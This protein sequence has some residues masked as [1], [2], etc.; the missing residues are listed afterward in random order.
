MSSA[1]SLNS[2]SFQSLRQRE[3]IKIYSKCKRNYSLFQKESFCFRPVN[4][5]STK[6]TRLH[7]VSHYRKRCHTVCFLFFVFFNCN[8]SEKSLISNGNRTEWSPIRSIIIR[9][10]TK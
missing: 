3:I 5:M 7:G 9:V 6:F 1:F 8:S 2:D 10:I 4:I